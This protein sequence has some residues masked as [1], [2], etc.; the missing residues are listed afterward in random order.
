M[1]AVASHAS[2]LVGRCGLTVQF[3][4]AILELQRDT[5]STVRLLWLPRLVH[6][7]RSFLGCNKE[8]TQSC[9]SNSMP[10][11]LGKA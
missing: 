8:S 7:R 11:V 6:S 5:S 9:M 4:Y 2:F 10:E 3:Q 1:T